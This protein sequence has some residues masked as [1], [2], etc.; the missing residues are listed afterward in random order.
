MARLR[1]DYIIGGGN[2]PIQEDM[3]YRSKNLPGNQ[4]RD[5]YLAIIKDI[6]DIGE[7]TTSRALE[8]LCWILHA[9]RPMTEQALREAVGAPDTEA[10][11]APCMSLVVLSAGLFQFSHTT[12]VTEFLTCRSNLEGV[13]AKWSSPLDIAKSC[14]RYLNSGEFRFDPEFPFPPFTRIESRSSYYKRCGFSAYA[15]QHWPLHVHDVERELLSPGTE[16]LTHFK[17]LTL[18]KTRFLWLRFNVMS[19]EITVLHVAAGAGLTQF[20]ELCLEAR[21]RL[22]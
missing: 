11:L 20:C 17:F 10:I 12:T 15:A 22:V 19:S 5:F 1:L 8:A 14:L 13:G 16:T 7:P 21:A 3:E 6:V 9:K 2:V 4:V 18:R